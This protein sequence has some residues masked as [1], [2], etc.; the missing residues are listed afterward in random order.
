M[1]IMTQNELQKEIAELGDT[2]QKEM[3]ASV[4]RYKAE[5]EAIER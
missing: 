2:Q 4:R 5:K 1:A 3:L